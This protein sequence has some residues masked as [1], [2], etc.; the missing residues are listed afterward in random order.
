MDH[1]L[2]QNLGITAACI[3]TIRPLFKNLFDRSN[4]NSK[5]RM[6]RKEEGDRRGPWQ[7]PRAPLV[8]PA[9]SHQPAR[10]V[11]TSYRP[12]DDIAGMPG[13]AFYVP[14]GNLDIMKTT[15]VHLRHDP[16]QMSKRDCELKS[17]QTMAWSGTDTPEGRFREARMERTDLE[18]GGGGRMG[19]TND[20]DL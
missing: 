5:V 1:R 20:I 4:S 6:A 3:P 12:I 15:E 18:E 17:H 13:E 14:M 19:D 7:F 16:G 2:E 10:A 9:T 11:R 8:S